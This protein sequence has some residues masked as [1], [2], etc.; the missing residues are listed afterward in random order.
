M[1][2]EKGPEDGEINYR[3]SFV[4]STGEGLPDWGFRQA[5]AWAE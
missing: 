5:A 3:D 4:I 2:D 1:V